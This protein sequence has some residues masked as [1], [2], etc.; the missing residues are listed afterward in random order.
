MTLEGHS[1][2]VSTV[3]FSPDGRQIASGSGD[4]TIRVWDVARSLKPSKWL[5]STVSR[6]PKCQAYQVVKTS[7]PVSWLRFSADG[8]CLTTDLGPFEVKPPAAERQ[9]QNEDSWPCLYVH[10]QWIHCGPR[11]VLQLPA[12]FQVACYDVKGDQL[13]IG[14]IDGRVL[15]LAIDSSSLLPTPRLKLYDS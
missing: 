10:D 2:G 13:A 6:R 14:F 8:T 11:R 12:A 1:D 15:A 5:G 3:V 9:I 4:C 7:G